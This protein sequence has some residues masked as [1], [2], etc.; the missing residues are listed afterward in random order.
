MP[1]SVFGQGISNKKGLKMNH[2]SKT[3]LTL[4]LILLAI[5]LPGCTTLGDLTA[6]RIN[7]TMVYGSEKEDWLVPLVE[8][9]NQEKHK[10]EDGSII[11]VEATPM[12]SIE[13]A[14]EINN[15]S[16]QPTIWSPASSIY[17]PIANA[18]WRQKHADDLI[19]GT[20]NDLVLSPIVIAMWKPMAEALGWPEK[21]LG[22]SDIGAMAFSEEG[23][24]A[25]GY[26]EW[27]NFK[28]GH[29]HPAYSNSGICAV[30]AS[31]YAGAEKQRDLILEDL[32]QQKTI[33]F[34]SSVE[35][36]IIHY[37]SSTGFFATRMFERGPS[38]LSAAAMYENLVVYQESERLS[39]NTQQLPVV[40]IYPKEG[41]FWSNHPFIILNANWVTGEQRSAAEIFEDFLL[42]KPQQLLAIEYGF[43][44]ADP[45]IP[46][47]S[48]LDE[49]HGVDTRQPQTVLEVPQAEVIR[50]IEELW[51]QVKKPVDLVLVVDTSG[52][53]G[54]EKITAVRASLQEFIK[55]LGDNDRLQIITFNT[56]LIEMTPLT[57]LG[58]KR[59]DISR[60]VTGIIENGD[61]RLYDAV[62][63]AYDGLET[64]GNPDHIRAIVVL[65]DGQDT[66]SIQ[67]LD[68]VLSKIGDN[69]ESGD[70]TKLFTIAYG[71]DADEDVLEA[72][73]EIT[74]G[75][76]YK[77]EPETIQEIYEAIA[78]FF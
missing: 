76:Q 46:L 74:G 36:S 40:A 26:P 42:D 57:L 12:G 60:R 25:F 70:A 17:L 22:W 72:I 63:S 71:H 55:L 69:S 38:Y 14:R 78:T 41:T 32:Q 45:S 20:P 9:F 43:R 64:A 53:M 13:T 24:S 48:P 10:T 61:T 2:N 66:A 1:C 15:G 8:Q 21:A 6:A 7:I 27:G 3:K 77:G 16:L 49:A 50:G 65:S 59:E 47:T 54:G 73:A 30:I 56:E 58:E 44:P 18:D 19:T 37:G 75:R 28:F 23:W 35:K 39:G 67:S 52:S 5:L 68:A 34:L 11:V 62:A 4:I 51:R 29:T 31:T 33:D